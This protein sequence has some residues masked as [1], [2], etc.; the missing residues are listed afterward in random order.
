MTG[1][2]GLLALHAALLFLA[3]AA[4][5]VAAR[6]IPGGDLAA[7]GGG[8]VVA[9]VV[10]Y[11]TGVI[12]YGSPSAGIWVSRL[13]PAVCV[14]YLVVAGRRD[15]VGVLRA[16]RSLAVPCA[17]TVLWAAIV[18]GLGFLY[19]DYEK[20]GDVAASRFSHHLPMD[21][22]LPHLF[23][24]HVELNGH[25]GPPIHFSSWLSSDRPP[26]Q[27][28]FEL[29]HTLWPRSDSAAWLD[30]QV[31]ATLLQSTWVLGLWALLAALGVR[32]SVQAL[33][34]V[35]SAACGQVLLNSF[36]TWP[37]LLAAAF[38]LV[39]AAFVARGGV[40]GKATR[41]G[42]AAAAAAAA[43]AYLSHGGAVFALIPIAVVGAWQALRGGAV[44]RTVAAVGAAVIP[45]VAPWTAYQ[46]FVD[47]P[48]DRLLKWMLADVQGIDPRPVLTV[49]A[50]RYQ[51]VGLAGALRNKLQNLYQ[52]V[53]YPVQP[54]PWAEGNELYSLARYLRVVWFFG[55]V[56][57]LG[58]LLV[59]LLGWFWCRR[60]VQ[61]DVRAALVLTGLWFAGVAAWC[62]L[63]F[64]PRTSVTHQGTYAFVLLGAAA[65]VCTGA[66]A[67]VRVTAAVVALQTAVTLAIYVPL[68]PIQDIE[69]TQGNEIARQALAVAVVASV[70]FA[71]TLVAHVRRKGAADRSVPALPGKPRESSASIETEAVG[72]RA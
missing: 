33:A 49:V 41:I 59:L 29:S 7:V 58:L 55:L 52:V 37:K 60:A 66:L 34:V 54:V 43:L 19:G 2:L 48:G 4:G 56:P 71:A 6:R 28:A 32:R 61:A 10:A 15:R 36:F 69:W 46:R 42:L 25:V 51:E 53:G 11:A 16:L 40:E 14:A 57:S 47:P 65:L 38:A 9:G 63:M 31:L 5:A 45:L 18:L 70:G 62:L 3:V 27:S 22:Q 35:G 39:A 72:D 67:S 13:T 50:G 23:A 44:L 17:L 24:R 12:W 20:A 21:N 68:H 1:I 8:L 26:L 64:G 30:Y